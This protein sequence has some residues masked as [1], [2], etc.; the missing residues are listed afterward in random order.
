MA[1]LSGSIGFERFRVVGSKIRNFSGE[2]LELLTQ[3]FLREI[4]VKCGVEAAQHEEALTRL[5]R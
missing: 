2:Q 3:Y 4:D 5:L 1:F